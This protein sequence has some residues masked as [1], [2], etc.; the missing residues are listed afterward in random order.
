MGS[1][2]LAAPS[3]LLGQLLSG[4]GLMV[5]IL[6]INWR[7]VELVRSHGMGFSK[8]WYSMPSFVTTRAVEKP[9]H[10]GMDLAGSSSIW[11]E[12]ERLDKFGY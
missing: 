11:R 8:V 4:F 12:G 5:G 10:R 6:A 1:S 3:P 7:I 9:R 2:I